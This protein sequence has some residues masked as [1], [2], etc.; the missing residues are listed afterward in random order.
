M[1]HGHV[2]ICTL[3][4]QAGA[5]VNLANLANKHGETPLSTAVNHKNAEICKLLVRAGA[6]MDQIYLSGHNNTYRSTVLGN[7]AKSG[8]VDVCE[9][10]VRAGAKLEPAN[11]DGPSDSTLYIA[12]Q[13]GW[14]QICELLLGAGAD[15]CVFHSWRSIA[16]TSLLTVVAAPAAKTALVVADASGIATLL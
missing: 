7:A 4:V 5:D 11:A 15:P 16:K 9:L 13:Y 12:A 10:L 1:K 3:L 2:E 8:A 14:V 6:D